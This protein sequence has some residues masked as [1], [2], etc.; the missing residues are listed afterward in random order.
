MSLGGSENG[1]NVTEWARAPILKQEAEPPQEGKYGMHLSV[2]HQD[3]RSK[4]TGSEIC[5]VAMMILRDIGND[6]K[7]RRLNSRGTAEQVCGSITGSDGE[8]WES[9]AV[10]GRFLAPK[11]GILPHVLASPF[12]VYEI[13]MGIN[14]ADARKDEDT[15]RGHRQKR[16]LLDV[17]CQGQHRGGY[18]RRF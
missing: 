10:S 16:G 18:S 9:I 5:Q 6:A 15:G 14:R 13:L 11:E 8:D 4:V 2:K 12:E 3:W 17:E 1:Q 7:G